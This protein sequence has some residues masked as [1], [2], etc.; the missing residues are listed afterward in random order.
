MRR[1][2]RQHGE[3]NI[4]KDGLELDKFFDKAKTASRK[5]VKTVADTASNIAGT[6]KD[7]V[8][9]VTDKVVDTIEEKRN[10]AEKERNEHF[11]SVMRPLIGT[12]SE[13]FI[14][15]L[16]NSPIKLTDSKS[17]QIKS[18]FPVPRE[19]NIL[20][21]DAEFDLRPSGIVVTDR[22]IFIRTNVGLL[23][24]KIGASNF[25]LDRLTA[26]EQQEFLQHRSQ[27]HNGKAVLIYYSWEDFD[28][29]WFTGET[30]IENKALLVEPQCSKRFVEVCKNYCVQISKDMNDEFN[31]KDFDDSYDE[32]ISKTSVKTG[33]LKQ[34]IGISS[35]C[36]HR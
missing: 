3:N 7:A 21:A 1:I 25:E 6:T 36:Y 24:G 29:S 5:V 4:M 19:Y 23:D 11:E 14:T 28:A 9:T 16:G 26:E 32:V 33:D 15:A 2:L 34:A 17:N 8:V 13:F 12:E 20:W 31:V 10:T 18:T 27:F 35:F 30:E 22:G